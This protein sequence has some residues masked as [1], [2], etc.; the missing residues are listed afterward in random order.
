[1]PNVTGV[2]IQIGYPADNDTFSQ[3][4]PEKLVNN[5]IIDHLDKFGLFLVSCIISCRSSGSWVT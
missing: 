1:M 4:K 2:K 3:F 5:R